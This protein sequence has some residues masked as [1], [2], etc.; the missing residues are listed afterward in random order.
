[1]NFFNLLYKDA[2]IKT[3]NSSRSLVEKCLYVQT[4]R[5]KNKPVIFNKM[6]INQ[7]SMIAEVDYFTWVFFQF[8]Q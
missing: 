1:M 5:K 8:M 7:Q 4:H 6:P 2:Q 3:L